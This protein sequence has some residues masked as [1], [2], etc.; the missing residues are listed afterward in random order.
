[1]G[2]REF[3]PKSCQVNIKCEYEENY[4]LKA[5]VNPIVAKYSSNIL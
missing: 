3:K 2:V 5:Y 1:M 4:A